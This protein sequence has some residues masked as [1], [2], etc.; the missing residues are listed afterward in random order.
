MGAD[1][2]P[3]RQR[4]FTGITPAVAGDSVSLLT[5]IPDSS[6]R[7]IQV[8]VHDPAKGLLAPLL[9]LLNVQYSYTFRSSVFTLKTNLLN[10]LGVLNDPFTV[11]ITY[12][13]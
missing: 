5:G 10:S 7:D 12:R 4:E 3:I 9:S 8:L 6:I 13:Q 11:L 1:A 2:P